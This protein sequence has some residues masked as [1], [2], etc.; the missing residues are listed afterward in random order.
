MERDEQNFG[1][2]QRLLVL[3]RHETPPPGY[4]DNLSREV[5][6]RIKA[7]DRG[8]SPGLV[9]T[10]SWEAT[11]FGRLWTAL[12][13][14][15][16]L[17]ALCGV[18]VCGL[19]VSG[20]VYSESAGDSPAGIAVFMAPEVGTGLKVASESAPLPTNPL[21]TP[22]GAQMAPSSTGGLMPASTQAG[23]LFNYRPALNVQP[24]SHSTGPGQ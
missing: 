2:L 22:V 23:S 19:L 20:L 13:A 3:K 17:A 5:I 16:A 11:W 12:E 18:A 6:V 15:P 7:G 1:N 4:F 10:L 8:E 14:R 24:A 9:E 21:L